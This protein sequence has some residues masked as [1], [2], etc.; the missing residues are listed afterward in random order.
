MPASAYLLRKLADKVAASGFFVAVPD[1]VK[2]EP[3]NRSNPSRP[4]DA[5]LKDHSTVGSSLRMH[6]W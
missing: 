6:A 1:F 3:F 2:G 4:M 5:W